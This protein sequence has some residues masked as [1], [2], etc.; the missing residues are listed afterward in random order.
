M[1][2]H[3]IAGIAK[4][5][6]LDWGLPPARHSEVMELWVD[7]FA[8]VAETEFRA[9]LAAAASK[10]PDRLPTPNQLFALL[11]EQRTPPAPAHRPY[12]S[13]R[14]EPDWTER[15]MLEAAREAAQAA[16]QESAWAAGYPSPAGKPKPSHKSPSECA[17]WAD[18][19][20]D[21]AETYAAM[22][23]GELPPD[24]HVAKITGMMRGV[25][26]GPDAHARERE[27][28]LRQ[29]AEREHVA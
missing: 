7:R 3:A 24:A 6:C 29:D 10:N 25:L 17:K 19:W 1:N 11:R 9:V 13:Y 21:L 28:S 4:Q 14:R 18:F 16:I 12:E 15:E 22:A 8:D 27:R 20:R 23:R 5:A 26:G 2:A